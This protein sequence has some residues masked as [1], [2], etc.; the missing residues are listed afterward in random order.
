MASNASCAH[1][2]LPLSRSVF[3]SPRGRA[4]RPIGRGAVAETAHPYVCSND[5]G[6]QQ[7]SAPA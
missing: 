1:K 2:Q 4:P 6:V 3:A 7:C 5:E